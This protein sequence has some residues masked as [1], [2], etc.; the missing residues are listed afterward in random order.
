MRRIFAGM[1]KLF[2]IF[3]LLI[4][5][6]T[7]FAQE[8]PEMPPYLKDPMVPEFE[9]LML[10]STTMFNTADIPDGQPV[11]IMYFSPDC[12]HCV[13]HI[14]QMLKHWDDFSTAQIYMVT[15][16]TLSATQA[17]SEKMGLN[18]KENITFGKDVQFFV[19]NHYD[20]KAFPFTAVYDKNKKLV[21]GFGSKTDMETILRALA[22]A[23]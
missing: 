23:K 22:M 16:M 10:D 5:A 2:L 13:S 12:S 9:M 18:L 7:T 17:L 15:P 4:S 19:M 11:I 1:K 21:G 14:E 6:A 3:A 20:I 8:E